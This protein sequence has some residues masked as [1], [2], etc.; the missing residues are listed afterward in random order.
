MN[1]S[2]PTYSSHPSKFSKTL[3]P[4]ALLM[5]TLGAL[6]ACQGSQNPVLQAQPGAQPNQLNP[7]QNQPFAEIK[8]FQ[9]GGV[10]TENVGQMQVQIDWPGAPAQP[11][12]GL[13]AIPS[14]TTALKIQISGPGQPDIIQTIQRP[15]GVYASSYRL[16]F[17]T[18]PAGFGVSLAKANANVC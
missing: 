18:L 9:I 11:D 5:L 14:A 4:S 13:L 6:S 15:A 2:T 10:K 7:A 12:F 8:S 1:K 3:M 16:I 17:L